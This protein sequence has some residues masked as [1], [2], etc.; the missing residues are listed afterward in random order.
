MKIRIGTRRSKLAL[1]QAYYVQQKLEQG[2]I[3]TEIM[4][5]DTKGDKILDVTIAKIGSKGVFTEEIEEQLKAGTI[6]IAVHSAKDMQSV[7]PEGFELIAFSPR[8]QVN[9]VLVSFDKSLKLTP[10]ASFTIGTSSTRRVAMLRHYFPNI[11]T[12]DMRGNLQ[13]RIKK[14]EDGQCDA[15]LLAYAGV[16]RMEYD[17]MIAEILPTDVFTPPVGQGSIAI[18]VATSLADA[19]KQAVK[20]LIN[21]DDSFACLQAERAYLKTLNGGCSIP[22]F[23]HARLQGDQVTLFGGLVSLDGSKMIRHTLLGSMHEA[24]ALGSKLGGFVLENGGAEILAEIRN[25]Q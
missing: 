24:A 22:S 23:A 11:R 13:T 3:D 9:D 6:D 15:L 7:L 12:V 8:E 21:D 2:G 20:S 19:K 18:E 14:L 10:N 17:H 1:W 5:I 4:E 16:H 25:S